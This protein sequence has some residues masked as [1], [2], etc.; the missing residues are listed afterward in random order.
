[1]L[2]YCRGKCRGFL[3]PLIIGCLLCSCA[4]G[5]NDIPALM[6]DPWQ[7]W[8]KWIMVH[9]IWEWWT[10][11]VIMRWIFT[12]DFMVHYTWYPFHVKIFYSEECFSIC[13]PVKYS[14]LAKHFVVEYCWTKSWL[15]DL[16]H[17]VIINH[18]IFYPFI[19]CMHY[20]SL[21][22]ILSVFCTVIGI[23]C[24]F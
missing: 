18:F 6:M 23:P 8:Y 1:M 5:F 10:V 2:W 13:Y 22:T 15:C 3:L 16:I 4:S 14:Y 21:V 12:T 20:K 11:L 7:Y 24:I 17:K 19:Q 9:C